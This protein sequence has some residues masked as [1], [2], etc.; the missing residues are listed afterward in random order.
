[1]ET[2]LIYTLYCNIPLYFFN[3][4]KRKVIKNNMVGVPSTA[5]IFSPLQGT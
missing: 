3:L 4:Q 1:M 5:L 2:D